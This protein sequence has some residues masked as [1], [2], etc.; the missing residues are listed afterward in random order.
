[1]FTAGKGLAIASNGLAND[2]VAPVNPDIPIGQI[3]QAYNKA[4][5]IQ[6]SFVPNAA[7]IRVFRDTAPGGS[8]PEITGSPFAAFEILDN[9]NGAGLAEN[10]PYYYKL[11]GTNSAGD[12]DFSAIFSGRTIV[13]KDHPRKAIRDKAVEMLTNKVYFDDAIV[14]VFKTR[15]LPL[16]PAELPAIGV[17]I[18]DEPADDEET[19]P[20][21]YKRTPQLMIDIC[22]KKNHVENSDDVIDYIAKQIE[23]LFF[24]DNIMGG[25]VDD[26][27]LQNTK[28]SPKID[29]K[30]LYM[31]ATIIFEIEYRTDAPEEQ[32]PPLVEDLHTSDIS[33]GVDGVSV[34]V[35]GHS[36][37][38][39]VEHEQ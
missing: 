28:I 22:L 5:L 7:A 38:A 6:S 20:R 26:L 11:K 31:G 19:A 30:D 24:I 9:N 8:Y 39:I 29:G 14:K 17:Y 21:E 33:I 35:A 16:F 10:T 27:K 2:G 1:M 23:D 3:L 25:L 4:L 13:G 18:L 15:F 34:S 36:I 12:S 37:D 32:G